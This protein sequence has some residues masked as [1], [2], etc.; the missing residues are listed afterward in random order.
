MRRLLI[1][2]SGLLAIVVVGVA[3]FSFVTVRKSFPDTN[4]QVQISS[5]AGD[6]EVKRDGLGIPQIYA[7]TPE[8]LFLA[9]G[10]VHA[11]D[12]FYEMDFRRHVTSGRLAELVGDAA[13][14]TD[15]YVRTLGWR[16]VA[17]KEVAL[18]DDTTLSLL[19]AYA[20]GVNSYIDNRSS[21]ELS[22]EY[23]VLEL[24]GPDYTPEPWTVVDSLAWIKAMA[25]DLRS[26]MTD[27]IDRVL[28]TEKL[29][30]AQV[31]ELYPDYPKG[32]RTIVGDE[33]TVRDGAFTAQAPA[34]TQE[35][36]ARSAVTSL[37]K[38]RSSAEALPAL[39][40]IGDGIGSNSW[41][42]DGDHTTT[43]EP[44]LANDPHLAPSMPGIWYQVGLHCRT[45][46]EA[47]P[48][49]VAG[50]SFSGLP[51]VVVGHNAKIAWGVTTMYADVADLY[52]ERVTGDTYEYDGKQVPLKTRRE[53]FK[54]AGEESQ[55]ITV[56]STRHGPI[57]SDLDEDAEDVGEAAQK[58]AT[59]GSYEVALRWTALTPEPTIKAVFALGRAQDWDDFR[60]AAKLFTVPSQNLV[61]ADVDGNIGYQS[62]GTIP[63][64]RQGDGR[65]P[66]PG[67]DPAFE[68]KGSIPFDELPSVLNPDEGFIVT[69]NNKVIGDQYPKLLGADTAAGYRSERIRELIESR[70]GKGGKGLDVQD[71]SSIQNDTYSANAARLVPALLKVELGSR[72]HRQG[73]ATLEKWDL[74][75]DADS[76]GAAYFNSVWRHLLE[77]TFHDELPEAVWPE[78]GERW[79]NVVSGLLDK[80]GSH[81][82][83]DV[84]TPEKE[85][86]DQILA[87]AMQDARD[88]L[89]MIQSRNPSQWRWGT[90]HKLELVNPTLGDS[91][92]GLVDK[93]FNRGPYRVGGG[94]G[95][96][97]AT[98][99]D[100]TEGYEVT[101]VPSMRMI[102]DLADL[103]RSRWIQLTGASGHAFH[104]HYVDQ[105]ERWRKGETVPWVFG[106]RAVEDATDDTLTLT[107]R[108]SA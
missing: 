17:E 69:A 19:K 51:G 45:V 26:N 108:G 92:V 104:D 78:G 23:A 74:K 53:T 58:N 16:R 80:P 18:L 7:D 40:G 43:G 5:L 88:E 62:P 66:V 64:R 35:G 25:W 12:R 59:R 79:F 60:A 97:D 86:R 103:D 105:Q 38:A 82:W 15:K 39:L 44:I 90:M 93:L 20:R 1:V 99:W 8:D 22:L 98:S 81:W 42:V 95:I 50:F 46:D 77:L 65:W 32:H 76:P 94:G 68:W 36:L 89:T 27:E 73:Q 2:I 71:M 101:S 96:V 9:Q 48:Y 100:A 24:T 106:R 87:T 54:I 52:L 10:Y 102:V 11:Q 41:V 37:K 29:T 63:V 14:D 4:G 75:Q 49:D 85:S 70:I 6:V 21:S 55:T 83:D 72:Y 31:E 84:S 34:P 13:L 3:I 33:G 61:Y 47:C 67:W 57:L 107:S 30:V 56:R 28:A 91:G